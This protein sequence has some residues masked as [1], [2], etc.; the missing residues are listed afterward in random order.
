M[1][2]ILTSV[3]SGCNA[4]TNAGLCDSA[5]P[6]WAEVFKGLSECEGKN[7]DDSQQCAREVRNIYYLV[8]CCIQYSGRQARGV[9]KAF[10]ATSAWNKI[11][12]NSSFHLYVGECSTKSGVTHHVTCAQSQTCVI[13]TSVGPDRI[14]SFPGNQTLIMHSATVLGSYN[15]HWKMEGSTKENL[16]L[17]PTGSLSNTRWR[18][19]LSRISRLLKSQGSHHYDVHFKKAK[20]LA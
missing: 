16:F 9:D 2:L 13:I 8:Y 11:P 7:I 3:R 14:H 17:G 6:L 10:S 12:L 5:L 19:D 20:K 15:P 18:F 4:V 1:I